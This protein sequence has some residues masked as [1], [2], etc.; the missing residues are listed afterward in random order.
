VRAVL[1]DGHTS[2]V[3]GGLGKD[4]LMTGDF[5]AGGLRPLVVPVEAGT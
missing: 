4:A 3:D 1:A 2:F 5:D